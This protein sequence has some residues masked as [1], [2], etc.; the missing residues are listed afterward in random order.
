MYNSH[1]VGL[2]FNG[3]GKAVYVADPNGQLIPGMIMEAFCVPF[4]QRE[5][6]PT[7]CLMEYNLENHRCI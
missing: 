7:T 1:V 2:V 5:A 6:K 3:R 4:Q